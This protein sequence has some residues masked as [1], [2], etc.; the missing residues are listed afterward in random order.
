MAD[1]TS[2]EDLYYRVIR[3]P[4]SAQG[5][6]ARRELERRAKNNPSSVAGDYLEEISEEIGNEQQNGHPGFRIAV[7]DLNDAE[8]IC[9]QEIDLTRIQ[10]IKEARDTIL[11]VTY[12]LLGGLLTKAL[13]KA[14]DCG[15]RITAIVSQGRVKHHAACRDAVAQLRRNG[16]TC[17][18]QQSIHTK[19]LICDNRDILI[20]SANWKPVF[21]DAA[22]RFTSP[23][24]AKKLYNTYSK[25]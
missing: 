3:S 14:A 23:E 20:G 4:S 25:L 11:V 19:L 17:K 12:V 2:A 16:I 6:A 22:L 1:N 5:H 13:M 24:L 8:F 15:K 9:D 21:R 10:M 18:H 7:N